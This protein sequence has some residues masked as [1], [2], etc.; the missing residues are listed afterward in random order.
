MYRTGIIG[1]G[2]WGP[3][4]VRNLYTHPDIEVVK[5]VDTNQERIKLAQTSYPYI[6]VSSDADD[7]CKDSTIDLVTI[8]TPVL[9]HYELGKKAIENGKHIFIEKPFT[10]TTKQAESLIKLAEKNQRLIMVDHTFLFTGA[11]R[12]IKKIINEGSLGKLYYYDSVRINLGLFQHDIN[13]I[14]D[15]APHDISIMDYILGDKKPISVSSVGAGHFGRR[16]EDVAYLTLKFEDNFIAHFSVNWLSPVKIRRTLLAG[17]KKMLVWNNL[18]TDEEIKIY[19]AGVEIKSKEGIYNM[20]VDYRVG[21]M[22][23]PVLDRTEALTA[24]I[25]YLVQCIRTKEK[26]INDGEAGFRVVNILEKSDLSLKSQ[27]K[28]ISI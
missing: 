22:Y 3:K 15:L 9:T 6:K 13:V 21:D 24:E 28:F 1:Y 2:Y 27:G 18:Q 10:S 26:P 4:I 5:I 8:A 20:L 25:H 14:W 23:S 17:D 16:L 19:D 7:I 12:K 11:V